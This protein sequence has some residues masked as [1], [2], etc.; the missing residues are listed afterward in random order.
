[1][2]KMVAGEPGVAKIKARWD[3]DFVEIAMNDMGHVVVTGEVFERNIP[4]QSL[5]FGFITDQTVLGP[6]VSDLSELVIAE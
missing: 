2:R 3:D 5:R 1:M 6:F 4:E